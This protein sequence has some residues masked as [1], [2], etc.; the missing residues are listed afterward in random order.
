M[1]ID[2]LNGDFSA[3]IHAANMAGS[4]LSVVCGFAGLRADAGKLELSPV[5]P[6]GWNGYRF[7]LTFKGA[8]I[9]VSV[10]K[11]CCS[12]R[13]LNGEPIEFSLYGRGFILNRE[14]FV[15]LCGNME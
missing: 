13:N 9:E 6:S 12:V 1:D 10:N 15:T 2:D 5:L 11:G 14:G 7:R 8:R 4:W 3:G